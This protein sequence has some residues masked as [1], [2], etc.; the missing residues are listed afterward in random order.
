MK[1]YKELAEM[2]EKHIHMQM[3]NPK[4]AL[5]KDVAYAM[6]MWNSSVVRADK[7]DEKFTGEEK[8]QLYTKMLEYAEMLLEPA[9][10]TPNEYGVYRGLY[11]FHI[12]STMKMNLEEVQNIQKG[13]L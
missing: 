3:K 13:Q 11:V 4:E 6:E 2:I 10:S 12:H 9:L 8:E 5:C 1:K 7:E